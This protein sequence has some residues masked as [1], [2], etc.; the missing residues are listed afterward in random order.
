MGGSTVTST[1]ELRYF[2]KI[3]HRNYQT[4][5]EFTGSSLFS[6]NQEGNLTAVT[7]IL[8]GVAGRQC[9]DA[10]DLP[11]FKAAQRYAGGDSLVSVSL[12]AEEFPSLIEGCAAV[13]FIHA[14]NS[15][16]S[17]SAVINDITD[18]SVA[19]LIKSNLDIIQEFQNGFDIPVDLYWHNQNDD[20]PL[21][22]FTIPAHEAATI[23]TRIG[24]VFSAHEHNGLDRSSRTLDFM[25]AIG[26]MY[27]LSPENRLDTCDSYDNQENF[28]STFPSCDDMERRVYQFCMHVWYGKRLG[29]AGYLLMNIIALIGWL[30]FTM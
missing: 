20:E 8:L 30:H 17:P 4:N 12:P 5:N 27:A 25:V 29:N 16:H 26:G 3:N 1:S 13:Y 21:Y 19:N 7:N 18:A 15:L 14:T 9:Y 2:E 28:L 22:Q 6:V 24:D 23:K 11:I 10:L